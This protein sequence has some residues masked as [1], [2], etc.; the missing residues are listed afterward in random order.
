MTRT[1]R[2]TLAAATA[3]AAFLALAGCGGDDSDSAADKPA[4]A[5]SSATTSD[6]PADEASESDAAAASGETVTGEQFAALLQDA[7]DQA[8]TAKITMDLGGM[9][10]GD[11]VADYTQTPPE[12]AMTM[13]MQALGGDVE[14]RMVD[15]TIYLKG[16]ALGGGQGWV[17]IGLDDPNSPLGGLGAQLDPTSQFKAFAAAVTEATHVGDEDVDG[18]TLDHYTATVDTAK[19]LEQSGAAGAGQAGVPDSMTQDW[20]F[21]DEGRIRKFSSD[22][23]ALMGGAG[24]GM[25]TI[26]LTMSDWGSDVTIEAPPADEVTPLGQGG[27]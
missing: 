6:E 7:L 21:D 1:V 10:T 18:E 20:W 23:G 5:E 26:T 25:G 22:M 16:A 27:A 2:R 14:V 15:G 19:L 9:G 4:A 17:S 11:G 24:A 12:L 3:T 13:T 8:T